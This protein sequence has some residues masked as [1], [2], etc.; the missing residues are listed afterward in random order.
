MSTPYVTWAEPK[1]GYGRQPIQV[2]HHLVPSGVELQWADPHTMPCALPNLYVDRV[3]NRWKTKC[4][5]SFG[6]ERI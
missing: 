4:I 6:V 5:L 1:S 3:C 2:P